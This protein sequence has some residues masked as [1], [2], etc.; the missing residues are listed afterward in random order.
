M[1]L[2]SKWRTNTI[3]PIELSKL[4]FTYHHMKDSY[5]PTHD[6]ISKRGMDYPIT[7]V[8][9]TVEQWMKRFN[10]PLFTLNDDGFIWAIT[11]GGMKVLIARSLNYE[12]I[13]CMIY[14]AIDDAKKIDAW[15]TQCDP[16]NN[17]KCMPYK[18][19]LDYSIVMKAQVGRPINLK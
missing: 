16:H 15:L 1:H 5:S 2:K 8:K 7:V 19:I 14:N 12:T 11:S 6:A 4:S 3:K 17:P 13:D 18:H 10:D 9:F